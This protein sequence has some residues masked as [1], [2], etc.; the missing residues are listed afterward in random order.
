MGPLTRRESL[1]LI[2]AGAVLAATPGAAAAPAG[3]DL[4]RPADLLAA[5]VKLRAATDGSLAIEWLKGVQ[6]GVVDAVL[7]PFFTLNSVTLSWYRPAPDGTFQGRR[8]EVVWHGDLAGNRP[9]DAF[10]NPYTGRTHRIPP[11]R[12]GPVPVVL[13]PEG[14]RLPPRLGTQR[15][16]AE[17]GIGP[18]VTSATRVWI[19]FETRTRL[20]APEVPVPVFVYN[21]TSTYEGAL[22][23]VLDPA[24]ASADCAVAYVS[25]L[26]WKPWMEMG[27]I[28]GSLCNRAA[29]EKVATF[30]ALP[31]D[32]RE[33]LSARHP[34]IAADP[35]AAVDAAPG[36]GP[37]PA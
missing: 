26:G 27:D 1:G 3:L 22:A 30:A 15:L 18:A 25:V 20:Y 7:T 6:Y 2:G 23:R 14:L 5:L 17:G 12:T 37:G 4:A 28:R 8:L 10:R 29:G 33:Y 24:V 32:H 11:V 16:E 31:A 36:T 13:G 21:E 34:D 19:P 35:R 9:L